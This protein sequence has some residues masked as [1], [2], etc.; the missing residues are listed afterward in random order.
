MQVAAV[1]GA[2][3]E[4]CRTRQYCL[5]RNQYTTVCC[6]V[7]LPGTVVSW[8]RLSSFKDA[9]VVRK[10]A[11][12][13]FAVDAGLGGASLLCDECNCLLHVCWRCPCV[14][15]R[16]RLTDVHRL[17]IVR[18][19]VSQ[20]CHASATEHLQT[21]THRAPPFVLTSSTA[22]NCSHGRSAV[23]M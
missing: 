2:W 4:V 16:Q 13:R 15:C 19:H 18:P 22:S 21:L 7:S 6:F 12:S 17:R 20:S 11:D 5:C 9:E 1:H 14:A 8:L 3:C 23:I 10:M